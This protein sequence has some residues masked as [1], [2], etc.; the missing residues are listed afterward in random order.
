MFSKTWTLF[1]GVRYYRYKGMELPS[2]PYQTIRFKT[3]D[4]LSIDGWYGSADQ[5]KGCVIFL[6]GYTADK[7]VLL[8]EATRIRQLGYSVLLIDLRAHGNSQGRFTSFGIK[9]TD[10][11]QK[12][13]Q[14][15]RQK[16]HK[17][18]ILYGTSLGAVI[19][20]KATAARLVIP[21]A[22]I[23][24]MPFGSLHDHI[25][26][27]ARVFGFPSEPYGTLVTWWMGIER[28]Y[29]GFAHCTI[30]YAKGVSCPVLLQWGA[31]DAFVTG[32]EIG[33]IERSLAS[34]SKNLVVYPEAGHQ[35]LLRADP[36]QW[37]RE[38]G[39]LLDSLPQ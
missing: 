5:A 1:S 33:S 13:Y 32:N 19:I 35:S 9:E 3:D 15:A 26:A 20:L 10:E 17:N 8:P 28:G 7:S 12:A 38:V 34:S 31:K 11:L 18:I 16:G 6:H 25:R 2:F 36:V 14:F 24:D 23:A 30:A 29:N 39:R 27:R 4:S 21:Q 22:I 37:D